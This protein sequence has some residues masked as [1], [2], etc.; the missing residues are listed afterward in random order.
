[1]KLILSVARQSPSGQRS[2]ARYELQAEPSQSIH[3]CLE[4]VALAV[5][6][7]LAF[8]ENCGVGTCGECGVRVNGMERLACQ[9]RVREFPLEEGAARATVEPLRHHRVLRD[10]VVDRSGHFSRIAAAGA[11]FQ[12]GP[13]LDRVEDAAMRR[14]QKTTSCIHCGLCVSACEAY[15]TN[16]AFV[17]PAALAWTAR[18]LA[19]PRDAAHAERRELSASA[20][21]TAGCIQCGKCDAVCPEHVAPFTAIRELR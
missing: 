3:D 16:A 15:P 19:D 4:H 9:A 6:P 8:R 13:E 2:T 12:P 21:G 20:A 17:G 14:L 5:D 1:M 11:Y 7:T 10:L 18:F